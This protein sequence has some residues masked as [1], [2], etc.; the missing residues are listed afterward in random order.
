MAGKQ[1]P[2]APL[3]LLYA[4][5][6]ERVEAQNTCRAYAFQFGKQ[7]LRRIGSFGLDPLNFKRTTHVTG[8][9]LEGLVV[10]RG[11]LVLFHNHGGQA[12][13]DRVENQVNP[14]GP[15]QGAGDQIGA[16]LLS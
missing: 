8:W 11:D 12:H 15:L 6:R 14:L 3:L 7:T 2:D 4:G 1:P 16:R 9:R 5:V 10:V 13:I